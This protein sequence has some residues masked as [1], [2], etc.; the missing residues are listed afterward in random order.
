[1]IRGSGSVSPLQ[2]P[3]PGANSSSHVSAQRRLAFG[4]ENAE[5]VSR[6]MN[7][8]SAPFVP[9]RSAGALVNMCFLSL[10]T[11]RLFAIAHVAPS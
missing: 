7:A 2:M 6:K 11:S 10:C 8:K 9:Q 4:I 5:N 1:V 3:M